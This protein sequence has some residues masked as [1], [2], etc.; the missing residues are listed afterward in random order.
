MSFYEMAER[1][2]SK[3]SFLDFVQALAADAAAAD[4][5]PEITADG[6]LNLSP[7]GWE[8]GSIAAFL[9]AM[10]TWSSANSGITGEPMV[11]E[12]ASWR[13]FAEILHSGK[14]YE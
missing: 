9:G 7:G 4:E 14:F 8:N 2:D 12:Q 1:V 13:A 6:K 10:S 3:E 5:E 11:S